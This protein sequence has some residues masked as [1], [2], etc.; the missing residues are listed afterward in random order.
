MTKMKRVSFT[1]P[2][3]V[4]QDLTYVAKRLGVS[5]SSLVAEMLREGLSFV[6]ASL[7]QLPERPDEAD[8]LRYRGESKKLIDS[9]LESA[10]RMRDDL[11]SDL[12]GGDD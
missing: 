9:R 3:E 10:R 7:R 1:L 8:A 4:D 2:P 6:S 5:R 11:F 12:G